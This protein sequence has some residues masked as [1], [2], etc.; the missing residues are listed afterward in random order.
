MRKVMLPVQ[1]SMGLLFATTF[2]YAAAGSLTPI[3][4]AFG[5]G[6]NLRSWRRQE[7]RWTIPAIICHFRAF[8]AP[9]L[10]GGSK[11]CPRRPPFM[12]PFASMFRRFGCWP[13]G[14]FSDQRWA[15]SDYC[16]SLIRPRS[17]SLQVQHLLK[18]HFSANIS[19]YV[20]SA[21]G[22]SITE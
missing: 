9:L 1:L 11:G 19:A 3:G 5:V 7:M 21:K 18:P 12:R 20:H 4:L 13:T 8:W 17:S 22:F 14:I 15:Y 10:T 6:R 16:G 2:V